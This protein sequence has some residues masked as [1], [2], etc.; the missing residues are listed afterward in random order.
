MKPLKGKRLSRRAF[1]RGATATTGGLVGV[2]A[3]STLTTLGC[4]DQPAMSERNVMG[5]IGYGGRGSYVTGAPIAEGLTRQG[6]QNGEHAIIYTVFFGTAP[7]LD[8][9]D[10][11]PITNEAIVRRLQK[12]CD[13]VDFVV[14][15]L[16]RG[17]T[18]QSVLNE[19]KDLKKLH[20]DGVIIFGWPRD[21]ELLR[22]G[23]PTINAMVV[24]DFM[25]IPYP[26]YKT[27]RVIGAFLDPWRFCADPGVSERMFQDLV[28]KVKLIKAL[29]RMKHE[30]ILTVTDSPYV[31]VT[32]GDV[33]KN[34]P[35]DYNEKILGLIE[36][37]FGVKVTK[38]G[39]KE[40]A[41]DEDVQNLWRNKSP[42]ANAIAQRWI[43]NA[44]KMM[45]TI[46]SEVV[47]SAKVYLAMKILMEKYG[48]AAM[49]FHIRSLIENPRRED[50]VTPALAT[51]EFQLHNV[52][53]K[54]QSHL[55][56]LLSEMLLQYA[57]GRPSM[58]GDYSVDTYNNTSIVQHCEGPWNAWGDERRVPYILVDHRERPVR[59]RSVTGGS[60][61][62]WILYPGDEPVTMWQIDVLGKEV[63]LHTGTAVPML[64]RSALYG[65]HFYSMM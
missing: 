17:A 43:R 57:Y 21:Y 20:Y 41:E 58:L 52:V 7:S 34:M 54:C 27:N 64:T 25:N 35:P 19:I 42:E 32:Y 2:S 47:R 9:T 28:A 36:E 26:L 56:I 18:M 13:G 24:N 8:D 6:M 23:L 45:N 59:G 55:N 49:A 1:L 39:T 61:A 3:V 65:D 11:E 63:L 10:L 37:T 50:Y 12:E 48:A 62:S 40:V 60:A 38:I 46:E 16:T 51:S 31:N 22:S 33:R 53:A 15:D 4:Q 29:K 44:K 5:P 14:R 30:R